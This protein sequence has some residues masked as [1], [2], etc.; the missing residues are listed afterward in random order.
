[1]TSPS[2]LDRLWADNIPDWASSLPLPKSNP[3]QIGSSEVAELIQTNKAGVDFLIIDTRRQDWEVSTD[4]QWNLSRSPDI[5]L[6]VQKAFIRT[7][8]NLPAQSFHQS[9]PGLVPILQTVPLVI[10][11]CNACTIT[12]RGP[13]IAAWYQ[14]ALDAAGIKTSSARILTGGIK[15]W[16]ATYGNVDELT[17]K[18]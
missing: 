4:A 18:I 8:I 17:A 7:A 9:L 12:A 6:F 14:D 2:N 16:V 10:F 11:Y 15:G 13:R 3:P 5:L 1:M